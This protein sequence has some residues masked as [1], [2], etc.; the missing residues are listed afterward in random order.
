MKTFGHKRSYKYKF[1]L[2]SRLVSLFTIASNINRL[3]YMQSTDDNVHDGFAILL[4]YGMS[5]QNDI[6]QMF[7]N[8]FDH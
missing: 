1:H 6:T 2:D 4:R 3:I 5:L 8:L 7:W